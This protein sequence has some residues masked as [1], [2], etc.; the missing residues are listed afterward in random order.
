MKKSVRFS[1]DDEGGNKE[2]QDIVSVLH[3]NEYTD[4]E[5]RSCWYSEEEL[6]TIYQS[7]VKFT[8]FMVQ[9][10]QLYGLHLN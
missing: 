1:S 10:K 7:D 8:M 4:D 6:N 2:K 5:I 3:R 9:Q